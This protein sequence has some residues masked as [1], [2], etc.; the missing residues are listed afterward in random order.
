MAIKLTEDQLQIVEGM[1]DFAKALASHFL[2]VME[3]HGLDQI[4]GCKLA[5]SVDPSLHYTTCNIHIGELNSDFGH[6]SI[7][8]GRKDEKFEVYGTNSPEYEML[9]ADEATRKRM[10][11]LLHREKPLPPDGLWIGDPRNDYPVGSREWDIN[12]SLS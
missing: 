2:T 9:F 12:D 3:N 7:A 11:K 5:I 6:V 1:A 8:K 4:E 10:E